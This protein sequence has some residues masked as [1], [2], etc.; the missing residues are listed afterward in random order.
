V[1]LLSGGANN[2]F[3]SSISSISFGQQYSFDCFFQGLQDSEAEKE[4]VVI[5]F[6][7]LI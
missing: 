3:I 6:N 5:G 2:A 4:K 1:I 7:N